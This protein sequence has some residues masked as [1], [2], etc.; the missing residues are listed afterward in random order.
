MLTLRG[1]K[2]FY[3]G[4]VSIFLFS[5]G[6]GSDGGIEGSGQTALELKGT[7][8]IG[9]PIANSDVIIRDKNGKKYTTLTDANGKYN[10]VLQGMEPPFI[11]KA[12]RKEK[13]ALFSV[14]MK[15]GIA[16]IHPLSDFVIRNWYGVEGRNI[17]SE[18]DNNEVDSNPPKES[19]INSITQSVQNILATVYTQLGIPEEFN[20][21]TS[22]F[23]ANSTGFDKLLD[24]TLIVNQNNNITINIIDPITQ[25]QATFIEGFNISTDITAVDEQPPTRPDFVN[26]VPASDSN[27]VLVWN[28]STDNVSVA[29]Y[30]VF[31]DDLRIASVA[32]PTF[33]DANLSA[34]TKY[35]Y[36]IEAFDAQGNKS[37]QTTAECATTLSSIDDTA[38]SSVTDLQV[39]AQSDSS[40][41]LSW[42]SV[43]EVDVL[44]YRI[45]RET[46]GELLAI[47]FV[48]SNVFVDLEL[49]SETNY[50]YVV[51]AFDAAGNESEQLQNIC[52]TTLQSSDNTAPGKVTNLEANSSSSQMIKLSWSPI[53]DV[54]LN[55]YRIYR[56]N[57]GDD[58]IKIATIESTVFVDQDLAAQQEY[59][60]MIKAIDTSGNESVQTDNICQFTTLEL[61]VTPPTVIIDLNVVAKSSSSVALF[62]SAVSDSDVMG[63]QVYRKM[64]NVFDKIATIYDPVFNDFNL[65]A[66][67]EYCYDIRAIDTSD[68]ISD[69]SNLACNTTLV[70]PNSPPETQAFPK[71]GT[72]TTPQKVWLACFD[73]GG[74]GC[75][76]TYYTLD[77]TEP[78]ASSLVYSEAI[79]ISQDTILRFASV[80]NNG[81]LET[82]QTEN[83]TINLANPGTP[84]TVATPSGGNYTAAQKVWLTCFDNSSS[85]CANT[86]YTLDSTDPTTSSRLYTEAITINQNTT[87]QFISIDSIGTLEP[88][89]TEQ[90]NITLASDPVLDIVK[91]DPNGLIVSDDTFINCGIS[92][93]YLYDLNAE[94]TLTATH[95]NGL[96]PIWAGCVPIGIDKCTVTMSR[97]REVIVTYI[98]QVAEGSA[99]DT[100]AEAQPIFDSAVVTG[101]MSAGDDLDYYKFVVTSPGTFKA[102]SIHPSK[103]HYLTLFDA[104]Q[105]V[106]AS[107]VGIAPTLTHSLHIG[108]YYVRVYPYNS[109][110]DLDVPYTLTLS[111]SVLGAPLTPDSYEE[112]DS[113]VSAAEISSAG[114]V[115]AYL[116]TSN[117]LD[118]F[119][120]VVTT[121]GTFKAASIHPSK[122]HYLTLFD[123]DQQV[124]ASVV[125]IAPTLTHSLHIGTYYVRVYPYN[126]TFD[127]DVPYTLTLSG[128]VLGAPLTPDSYEENDSFVSAAKISSAGSVDAY[129]DTSNDLDYFKFVVTTPGTFRAASIHPS[130]QHYLT[131]FDADQQVVASV[132]GIAPT[133]THSLTIGTYYVRV[134]PYDSTFDLDVPYTLSIEQQ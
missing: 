120:F 122:Q 41:K 68:N 102:A 59:C 106:V 45:Y 131:L 5:C 93:A 70:A 7:V 74:S 54:D 90:F 6:G 85:G 100:F 107:V 11:L 38:P 129:L 101:F 47:A 30:N 99:N 98:S 78:S 50:C 55:G 36:K 112:N 9:A 27:I 123:A 26:A 104:D 62:W 12:I 3:I 39:V 48:I 32:F 63:Y 61:D 56:K 16:N 83:Y 80:D 128:S 118:Y 125:G 115:D 114:S 88:T 49:K 33:V 119:K 110:F 1:V 65:D 44:A 17:E 103:Q 73:R 64:N 130:K 58:F 76:N 14:A 126:S 18:F 111:G 82:A 29:G 91:T 134:Y 28:S 19:E 108:T 60:Y 94:V 97:A 86:Y 23:N 10:A 105:Q 57:G 95:T 109:T 84:F 79:V 121:P 66:N 117:D 116:D 2:L 92:C 67:T 71:T 24:L 132:V 113:F 4:L 20:L 34:S 124:V 72:F 53:T 81:L 69:Q 35:C 15:E 87:L 52:A 42:S 51:K 25:I 13:Q 89:K 133:L 75:V 21:L 46:N 43:N 31:K 40:I 96:T 37:V 127:L 22:E 8:A 77:G